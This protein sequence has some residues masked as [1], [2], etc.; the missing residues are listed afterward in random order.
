[1]SL[2][3]FLLK[4]KPFFLSGFIDHPPTLHNDSKATELSW[5]EF[6][7]IR[8]ATEYDPIPCFHTT[9]ISDAWRSETVIDFLCQVAE[10]NGFNSTC[11]YLSQQ[12]CTSLRDMHNMGIGLQANWRRNQTQSG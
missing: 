2:R 5:D 4:T 6:D 1:M 12:P 10:Q 9:D 11:C 7:T 8:S 3:L